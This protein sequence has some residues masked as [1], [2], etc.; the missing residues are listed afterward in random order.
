MVQSK[1]SWCEG[2]SATPLRVLTTKGPVR[3]EGGYNDG[4]GGLVGVE[5]G[6]TCPDDRV[7]VR[8]PIGAHDGG[9]LP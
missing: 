9:L 8:E 1:G 4:R 7:V 3:N 5:L 2:C 6:A